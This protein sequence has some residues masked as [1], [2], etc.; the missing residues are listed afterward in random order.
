MTSV[1][2]IGFAYTVR[3]DWRAKLGADCRRVHEKGHDP[4]VFVF[5][6]T[7]ALS[8]S[9]KDFAH[10]FV[11]EKFGWTLD[12]FDLER[13]RVQL[14]GPQRH[15]LAQHPSIFTPPF[16]PQ[17]GGQSVAVSRDDPHRPCV[18]QTGRPL[19]RATAFCSPDT[20]LV[21]GNR[22]RQGER[23]RDR[24][25]AARSAR[26]LYLPVV[27]DTS[28]ADGVFLER[29][30]IA[31]TT[32]DFVLPQRGADSVRMPAAGQLLSAEF[33]ASWCVGRAG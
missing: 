20:G 24:S 13:L 2:K 9:D 30:T 8:A 33:G 25:R 1:R 15:L 22:A 21:S 7:A 27:T 6:C 31:G 12:L 28:L 5:V 19:A 17:R 10:K 29:C 11:S 18:G 3:S 4:D 26:Q 14:A 16:F 23:G 32:E